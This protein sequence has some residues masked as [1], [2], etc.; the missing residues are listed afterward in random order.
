MAQ[1]FV[2]GRVA[3]D[4]ELRKSGNGVPYVRFGLFET[5]GHRE[6]SVQQYYQV[7][8]Y[9]TDA[10]YL[11]RKNVKKG[12][13]LWISGSLLLE[14]YLAKD[15]ATR[16]KRLKITFKDGGFVPGQRTGSTAQA[17]A[18]APADPVPGEELPNGK[19]IDGER[20][21]LPE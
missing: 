16:D 3:C 5:I 14:D 18:T 1:I 10:E 13:L 20:D 4:L 6:N 15:G 2:F 21:P 9:R 7:W 8:A 11:V 12:S 19:S 17:A